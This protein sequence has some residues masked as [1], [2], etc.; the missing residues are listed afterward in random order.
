MKKYIVLLI[1]TSILLFL[2]SSVE[3]YS[4]KLYL[5]HRESCPHCEDERK[6]LE[7]IKD[8]YDEL[9]ILQYEVENDFSNSVLLNNVKKTLGDDNNY[10]PY[11]V[12]GSTSIIGY[13]SYSN[14]TIENMI[15]SCIKTGCPDVVGSVIKKGNSLTTYELDELKKEY[16]E[17]INND[18]KDIPLLGTVNVKKT[19]LPLI[20]IILGFIDGFNPCAMWVLIFLINML[21]GFKDRKKMW[22]IGFT[23]LFCSGLV[24]FLSMLGMSIV[25]SISSI[26]FI[27]NI[28]A[29]VAIIVGIIHLKN[30]FK[31]KNAGCTVVDKEKRVKI[32]DKIKRIMEEKNLLLAVI[33][34]V[35]LAI[36]VNLIELTCSLGFPVV[37]SEILAL[38]SVSGASK[39]LYL[40]LYVLF[41]MLD[42]IIVFSVAMITFK[43]TGLTNKFNKYSHLIGGVIMV[44][45]GILMIFKPDWIMFNFN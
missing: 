29:I 34:V 30:F 33:G 3:A 43:L 40:L 6:Y 22:W 27:R 42:D 13:S 15:E 9:E 26:N 19:S 31:T 12:V 39:I 5:F 25:L 44:I 28:I 2:P 10:V 38:N 37:Y 32:T 14:T 8:K 4:T 45:L 18:V 24:Y 21:I 16:S 11:T 36:S 41:Y 17:S 20:G 35:A 1:L 23:F 7:T